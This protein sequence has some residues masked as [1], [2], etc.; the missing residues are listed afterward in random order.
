[1]QRKHWK[2]NMP[3]LSLVFW[4]VSMAAFILL[5][6]T[7]EGVISFT[8]IEVWLV[9]CLYVVYSLKVKIREEQEFFGS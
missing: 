2:L 5:V 3:L 1:M 6:E 8:A 9:Y 4:I 7:I